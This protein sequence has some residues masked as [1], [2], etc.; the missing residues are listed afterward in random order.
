MREGSA[1]CVPETKTVSPFL[2][3]LTFIVGKF[4]IIS[5]KPRPARGRLSSLAG[6]SGLSHGLSGCHADGAGGICF[7]WVSAPLETGAFAHQ[8]RTTERDP[9]ST[10]MVFLL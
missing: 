5:W 9:T 1:A 6:P 10:L 3:S 7:V 2:R 8:R 4:S